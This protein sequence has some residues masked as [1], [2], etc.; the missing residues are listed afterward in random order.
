MP[1]MVDTIFL[2]EIDGDFV[3][4]IWPMEHAQTTNKTKIKA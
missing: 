3:K 4:L 1:C 2:K